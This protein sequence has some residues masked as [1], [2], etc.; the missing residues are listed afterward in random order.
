MAA[1]TIYTCI[2]TAHSAY[3]MQDEVQQWNVIRVHSAIAFP[4]PCPRRSQLAMGEN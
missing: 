1:V 3:G 2:G 4:I